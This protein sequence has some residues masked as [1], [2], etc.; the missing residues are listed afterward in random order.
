MKSRSAIEGKTSRKAEAFYVETPD[1]PDNLISC[2]QNAQYP[3]DRVTSR[4]SQ[5]RQTE[6]KSRD[7]GEYR[8]MRQT[9]KLEGRRGHVIPP[10][11]DSRGSCDF[12]VV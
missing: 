10:A 4:R 6:G 2:E 1:V 11:R 5:I 9:E 12:G 3:C 8:Q 7:G